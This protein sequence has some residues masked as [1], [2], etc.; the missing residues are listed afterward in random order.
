MCPSRVGGSAGLSPAS[1]RLHPCPQPHHRRR[2]PAWSRRSSTGSGRGSPRRPGRL[3]PSPC[4]SRASRCGCFA[5]SGGHRIPVRRETRVD[6]SEGRK[7]AVIISRAGGRCE[8]HGLIGGRCRQ[9]ESLHADHVHPR[10]RG[11]SSSVSNAQ[12]L[13]SRHNKQKAA[14]IPYQWELRRLEKPQAGRSREYRGGPANARPGQVARRGCRRTW[15][16]LRERSR[17]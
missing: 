15:R 2:R 17:R 3:P 11:G 13:C 5:P 6:G 8:F 4:C 7:R 9:T 16:L 10:S 12:A 14:R 1:V